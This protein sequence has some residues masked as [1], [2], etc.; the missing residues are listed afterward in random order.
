MSDSPARIRRAVRSTRPLALGEPEYRRIAASA[1]RS[2]GVGFAL[3]AI[4]LA[5]GA[6]SAE[7]V[8]A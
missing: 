1:G 2:R 4:L 6:A 5:G 8:R 3:V 7:P